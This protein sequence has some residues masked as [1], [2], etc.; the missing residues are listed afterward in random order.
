MGIMVCLDGATQN[1]QL[2][3]SLCAWVPSFSTKAGNS[4]C[5]VYISFIAETIGPSLVLLR[6]SSQQSFV[7]RVTWQ[8]RNSRETRN[9]APWL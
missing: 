7:A 2:W 8:E 9:V 6:A 4:D 1:L 3:I 5:I